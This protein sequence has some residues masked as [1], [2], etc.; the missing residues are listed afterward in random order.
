MRTRSIRGLK[1]LNE[2]INHLALSKR[3][4]DRAAVLLDCH[5]FAFLK[6]D[7]ASGYAVNTHADK[8]WEVLIFTKT[9]DYDARIWKLNAE[10][11]GVCE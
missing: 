7:D 3:S 4:N 6:A 5:F 10:G 8:P 11:N 1:T 2:G 9:C